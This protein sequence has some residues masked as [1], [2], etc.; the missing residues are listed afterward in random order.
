MIIYFL[1]N[2]EIL[3]SNKEIENYVFK[4]R[5]EIKIGE[6]FTH[7]VKLTSYEIIDF[8]LVQINNVWCKGVIY[9]GL[10][11]ENKDQIFVR[12][13]VDFSLKFFK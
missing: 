13:L 8:C 4:H 10:N 2:N 11:E 6:T 12:E 3:I 9:K 5:I 1:E 7:C